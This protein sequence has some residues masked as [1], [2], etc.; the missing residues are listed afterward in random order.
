MDKNWCIVELNETGAETFG[1][2]KGLKARAY[3]EK[4]DKSVTRAHK[5]FFITLKLIMEI[6]SPLLII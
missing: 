6:I 5:N 1:I 3:Y 4:D 2:H